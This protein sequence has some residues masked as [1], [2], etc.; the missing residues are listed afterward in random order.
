MK[1]VWLIVSLLMGMLELYGNE[2]AMQRLIDGN[3]RFVQAQPMKQELITA[4]NPFCAILACA[5]SRVSPELIFDQG[6]GDLFVVR[7]AGN[8]A[9]QEVLESLDFASNTLNVELI[10]VMGHQNC[11]AVTAVLEH[12]GDKELGSIT[13]MIRQ[14]TRGTKNLKEATI[15]NIKAQV[16]IIQ[17]HSALQS[18]LKDGSL[19]VEG[20][21]YDF[22]TGT[23]DFIKETGSRRKAAPSHV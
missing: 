4:Q 7:I 19:R 17:S 6:L 2:S 18:R 15:A 21:Y 22:D 20:A 5:D 14:A 8:V 9:S 23:V 3:R 12:K 11:G 13:T 16:A 10:L 1:H